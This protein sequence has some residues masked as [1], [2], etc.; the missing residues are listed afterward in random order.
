MVKNHEFLQIPFPFPVGFSAYKVDKECVY[1]Y[2]T[3]RKGGIVIFAYGRIV[4]CDKFPYMYKGHT[5][6]LSIWEYDE[7]RHTWD[8][9]IEKSHY[10][11]LLFGVWKHCGKKKP[12]PTTNYSRLMWD[13][14]SKKKKSFARPNL[15]DELEFVD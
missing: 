3:M 11:N 2:L 10:T 9:F 15:K 13:G 14:L 6:R 7:I 12:D 1:D 8:N 5:P 4:Y